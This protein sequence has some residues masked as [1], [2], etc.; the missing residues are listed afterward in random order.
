MT[1][2]EA[3][4][5]AGRE[6]PGAPA[7]EQR[8]AAALGAR[9]RAADDALTVP[10][11]LW[12]R[13]RAVPDPVPRRPVAG[14][15]AVLAGLTAVVVAAVALG[16]WLLA[17]PHGPVPPA[18][19]KPVTITVYNTERDCQGP[20]TPDCALRVAKD[21]HARY[22][23]P[24]NRAGAVWH[25]DRLT[26][27]CAVEGTPVRDEDGRS[28]ARWYRVRGPHGLSGWLPGVRTRDAARVPDC[29]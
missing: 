15:P 8:L 23:A 1:G 5:P 29:V 28:S 25:G 22:A 10:P 16:S 17:R 4:G 11:G 20:R 26:A 6:G 21:P 12:E 7:D 19:A 18:G 14:R 3:E 27:S 24:D 9:L 2:P 13:V